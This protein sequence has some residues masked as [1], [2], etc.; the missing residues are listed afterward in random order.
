MQVDIML[1]IAVTSVVQS[2]F[3]AGVLLFGTPILLLLG[4][5]FIEILVVLLPISI[6]INLLQIAKHHAHIDLS[7]YR[8]VLALTLPSIMFFLFLV[9]QARINIGF[10]VGVFLL[11]IAL[12]DTFPAIAQA[13]DAFMK[14]EKC[15][16]V[17]MG[18]VH[19]LSNLGGS[20]LT[21]L[22]HHKGYE[23]D[24]ARVT[25]AAC[26]ATFALMQILTLVLFSASEII[27]PFWNNGIYLVVG[28][29][30]F[31]LTDEMLYEGLASEKYTRIFAGFLAVSG[32]LLTA[33]SLS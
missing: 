26:Y 9:I 2:V 17:G 1:T 11:A 28:A 31:V 32:I 6:A 10:I 4:Y 20:L 22:V 24:V 3:G 27:G 7:F 33:K 25:V 16:F 23:K 12:K 15:Y 29:M 13:L 14:Y 18:V 21:A 19:G 5:P 8:K 30:I